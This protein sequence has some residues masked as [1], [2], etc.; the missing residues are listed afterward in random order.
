M[1]EKLEIVPYYSMRGLVNF[2]RH[3][4]FT[5][6][7]LLKQLGCEA[8]ALN[9]QSSAFTTTDYLALYQ[10]ALTRSN[11]K[12]LGFAHGKHLHVSEWG[13]LGHIVMA[14]ENLSQAL[15]FQRRYQCLTSTQ[16]YAYHEQIENDT[17]MRWLSAP[18]TPSIIIEEVI[19]AWV[20]FAFSHTISDQKP[21]A[22]H[23]VH[24]APTD[25]TEYETFFGCPVVFNAQFN[26]VI[27]NSQSLTLPLINANPEVLNVLCSHAE[28]QLTQKKANASLTLIRQY[29]IEQLPTQV[30]SLTDIAEH[31]TISVR[32]L[33]RKFQKE[34]T[35]LTELLEQ[36][37]KN[38]A[39]AYLTQTDHKL[40]FI[41]SKLGYSEQSA[42]QRAFKRWTGQTPQAFRLNPAITN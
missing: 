31:L 11:N 10:Y 24:P 34:Q 42:F 2:L 14:S 9:R 33:Q 17:I 4:G 3:Q 8:A 19:T 12:N 23:F 16:G 13:I 6:N 15:A 39:I 18:N 38:Q 5:Y 29:I 37:R 28:I 32:Q 22:V 20:A 7:E 21:K 27:I 41:A 36:I 26:G 25:V 30:P 40:I 1:P 35:N